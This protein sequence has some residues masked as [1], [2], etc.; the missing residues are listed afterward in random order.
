MKKILITSM[1]LVL[2]L[3]LSLPAFAGSKRRHRLKGAAIGI[4]AA[5]LGGA[6]LGIP[7]LI[8]VPPVV[9]PNVSVTIRGPKVHGRRDRIHRQDR[10]DYR[11]RYHGRKQ[12]HWEYR[13]VWVPA[14]YERIWNPGH[15][16]RK[17]RWIHG[18]WIRIE[19]SEGYWT[20]E[21]V[22]VSRR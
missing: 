13:K 18:Q 6:L 5:M 19:Q 15:Y 2:A 3:S 1:V 8:P 4:G 12:G 14:Q 17:N 7:P 22:W 9:L 16:N 21:K 10:R 20:R 11:P